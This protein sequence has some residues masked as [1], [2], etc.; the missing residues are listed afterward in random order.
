VPGIVTVFEMST[1]SRVTAFLGILAGVGILLAVAV[2]FPDEGPD[3]TSLMHGL[4]LGAIVAAAPAGAQA[5]RGSGSSIIAL[6]GGMTLAG[7][8]TTPGGNFIGLVMT[9]AGFALLLAGAPHTSKVTWRLFGLTLTFGIVL[10]IGMYAGL[11][12]GPGTIIPLLLAIV[13]ATSPR[14]IPTQDAAV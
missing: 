6:G 9:V 4:G 1:T 11:A 13:V 8:A 14:W 2:V 5:S 7:A 3:S 12:P 10:A